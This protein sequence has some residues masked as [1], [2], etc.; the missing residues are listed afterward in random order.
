[1]ALVSCTLA[2]GVV[3]HSAPR[4]TGFQPMRF[5]LKR[6]GPA[7]SCGDQ[8]RTFLFAGGLITP[9]TAQELE[10]FAKAH[11]VRGATMV[12]DSNGGSVLGALA[13]GRVVRNLGLITTVGKPVPFSS[14]DRSD[15]RAKLSPRATCESMCT[16]VLL[17]GVRRYVMPEA[18]VLVHQIWLGDRRDDATAATYSAEDLVLVQHDIGRLVRYVQEMGGTFELL[19]A[20]LRIPPW[21]PLRD[22]TR[23]ELRRMALDMTEETTGGDVRAETTSAPAP[24]GARRQGSLAERGWMLIDSSGPATLARRHP[25]TVRGDD[26][27]TFD[28]TFSCGDAEGY[29]VSYIEQRSGQRGPVRQIEMVLAGKTIPLQVVSSEAKPNGLDTFARATVPSALVKQ[30]ADPDSRS[31]LIETATAAK[32]TTAVRIGNAGAA[33]NFA[34]FAAACGKQRNAELRRERRR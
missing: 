31:V 6:E 8:C 15:P 25:L 27:G 7:S 32:E 12:L 21:E 24:L 16:F 13:L 30:F 2:P 20:T 29:T 19:E 17:A 14:N 34:Q 9:D 3:T 22:L 33:Q 11:D 1:M 10:R 28:L 23:E 26:I 4:D 5:E 18:H